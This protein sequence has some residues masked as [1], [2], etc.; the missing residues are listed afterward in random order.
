MPGSLVIIMPWLSSRLRN[1]MSTIS[2]IMVSPSVWREL[3]QQVEKL[4]M[5][6]DYV[7]GGRDGDLKSSGATRKTI[8]PLALCR[9]KCSKSSFAVPRW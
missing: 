6:C 4:S 5:V 3:F 8:S 2:S 1:P 9:E 7:W